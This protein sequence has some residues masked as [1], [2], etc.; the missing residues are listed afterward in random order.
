MN[1]LAGPGEPA[2]RH[3]LDLR[4]ALPE[5]RV[6]DADVH[7]TVRRGAL[8]QVAEV[9]HQGD[10]ASGAYELVLGG[11]RVADQG[12]AH[13]EALQP[14]A[15]VEEF[16]QAGTEMTAAHSTPDKG[17][18]E[19]SLSAAE[20]LY[21][22]NTLEVLSLGAGD[23]DRPVNA[24]PGRARAVL[25]LRYVVDT[26][27][28]RVGEVVAEHLA[29]EGYPMIDVNVSQTFAAGRTPPDDPWAVWAKAVLERAAGRPVAVLPNI[30][31][32]LPHAVF[33]DVLGLPA[34]WLPHSYPGCRQH[35]PDEHLLA[36][37]A[38]EGW[39]WRP[40]CSTPWATR[41]PNS[42][43]RGGPDDRSAVPAHAR[44]RDAGHRQA[45]D[46]AAGGGAAVRGAPAASGECRRRSSAATSW[47]VAPTRRSRIPTQPR[48]PIGARFSAGRTA[49][50]RTTGGPR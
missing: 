15:D 42:R 21:A 48:A 33:T 43:C 19:P 36:P 49:G 50:L 2:A 5:H 14:D 17:W 4:L 28:S 13:A 12:R 7:D 30:G 16:A 46:R 23:V 26:D 9:A 34:L 31:G 44:H 29:R 27:V 6:V 25:Q 20:R 40:R 38:R 18:D 32:S 22:W 10:A 35:A 47:L 37:I 1:W 8:V 24:I 39:S 45:R 41:R 3:G 11:D